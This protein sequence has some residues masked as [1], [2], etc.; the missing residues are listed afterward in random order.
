[1]SCKYCKWP[2]RDIQVKGGGKY[3]HA[4]IYGCVVHI[5]DRERA[6]TFRAKYCP[7]CG[8]RLVDE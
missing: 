5:T 6:M 4:Y 1:M 8:R 2:P 7:M 3:G